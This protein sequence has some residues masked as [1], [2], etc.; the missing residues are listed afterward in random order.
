M[1]DI[2]SDVNMLTVLIQHVMMVGVFIHCLHL[3][4][5]VV[6]SIYRTKKA[7]NVSLLFQFFSWDM[8]SF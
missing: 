5:S 1:K 4:G 6:R 2:N 7:K 3:H 8:K